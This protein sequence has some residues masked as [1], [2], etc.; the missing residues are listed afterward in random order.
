MFAIA[1]AL[2]A[3]DLVI[4]IAMLMA[5]ATGVLLTVGLACVLLFPPPRP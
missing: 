1:I 2:V 3:P 4:Q 5:L